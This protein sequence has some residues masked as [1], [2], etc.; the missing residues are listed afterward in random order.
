MS[1]AVHMLTGWVPAPL[2]DVYS[3]DLSPSVQRLA[4][5]GVPLVESAAIPQNALIATEELDESRD[6]HEPKV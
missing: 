3:T 4:A 2:E 6:R 5:L 1:L